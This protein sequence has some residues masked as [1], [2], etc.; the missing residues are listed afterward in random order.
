LVPFGLTNAV[1]VYTRKPR[2]TITLPPLAI[3]FVGM[4]R[5]GPASFH[6]LFSDDDL[7]SE[8]SSVG[9]ISPLGCLAL[10]EYTMVDVQ[11]QLPVPVR[12]RIHTSHRT[13][14]QALANA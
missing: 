2:R 13:R 12:S 7:L 4:T 8:G 6:D 3:K 10:R 11:G 14:A 9:D 1:S 5:Y